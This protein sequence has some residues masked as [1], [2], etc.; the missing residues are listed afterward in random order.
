MKESLSSG[1]L[2]LLTELSERE[3]EDIEA[4]PGIVTG[5][6]PEVDAAIRP[7]ELRKNVPEQPRHSSL[8]PPESSG[9]Q[10]DTSI[11]KHHAEQLIPRKKI[12]FP[13]TFFLHNIRGEGL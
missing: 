10:A 1:P 12:I 2:G 7:E 13:K 11:Y 3:E 8:Q 6:G 4:L 5:I 9:A